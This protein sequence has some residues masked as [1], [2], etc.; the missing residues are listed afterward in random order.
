M[1]VY[2]NKVSFVYKN[3][4]HK[5]AS[6]NYYSAKFK[7]TFYASIIGSIDEHSL[8]LLL[9]QYEINFTLNSSYFMIFSNDI[10]ALAYF[11]LDFQHILLSNK[12]NINMYVHS[13]ELK[14]KFIKPAYIS[15]I[16]MS[17]SNTY[18]C[19]LDLLSVNKVNQ[20]IIIQLLHY[21]KSVN[22][23]CTSIRII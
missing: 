15:N 3:I 23:N 6:Y 10:I 16:F 1:A 9:K 13:A 17:I 18:K 7:I 12:I 14:S 11:Y 4:M 20:D 2:S 21:L 8:R 5:S 22:V 19:S